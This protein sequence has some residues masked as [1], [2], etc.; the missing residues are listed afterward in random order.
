M[1]S[2]VINPY[3][4]ASHFHARGFYGPFP[5]LLRHFSVREHFDDVTTMFTGFIKK[6]ASRLLVAITALLGVFWLRCLGSA[7]SF[8]KIQ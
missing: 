2:T 8:R 1:G 6:G 4:D 7:R 3:R 5:S